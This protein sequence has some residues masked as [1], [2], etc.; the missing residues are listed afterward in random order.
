MYKK[1]IRPI[2]FKFNPELIHNLTNLTGRFATSTKSS[3]LV[4]PLFVYKNKKLENK[5]LNITFKNPI[6]LAAG[7]DKN[8]QLINFMADL[9]FGFTEV[10]SITANFCNGN[11]KPRLH[12]LIKEK[13]IIVN[14]GLANK[15]AENIC[16]KLKNK[17]FKIPLGISIA[18]T[19]DP[20][21][22]GNQSIN[23]YFKSFKLAKDI[24]DYI[25]INISCPNVGDGRTFEDPEL[26]EKLL[27]KINTIKTKQIIFLKISPDIQ[28]NNLDKII[29][30][31]KTYKIN[32]FLASNLTK[33][34]SDIDLEKK[35]KFKGGISGKPTKDKSNDLIKYLY[36]KS[37]GKFIIIGCGGIFNAKD[38][39]EKIK[40]GAS[41]VQLVTGL[42]FE[43]PSLIKKINKELVELLEKDN[44]KN[45]SE[46]IGSDNKFN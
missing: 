19:N 46:A 3:L 23:D 22:K 40:S 8:A 39:Y 43:G 24:A 38:A 33:D 18:K 20:S 12:R 4:R 41:L 27:K 29:T 2:L 6:G 31:A 32:G 36:K 16:K 7:F 44:Y 30:L 42:I 45:I 5:I 10:G 21:I 1:F 26:L 14:Y 28:K 9:G 25:T 35:G 37:K 34:R 11:P 13:G 17:K 15:G